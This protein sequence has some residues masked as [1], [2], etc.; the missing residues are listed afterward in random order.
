MSNLTFYQDL[1]R[2]EGPLQRLFGA[3]SDF[4]PVPEDWQVIVVDIEGSSQAVKNGLHQEVNLAATGS[5]IAVLNHIK[6]RHGDLVIPYWFGGDGATFLVPA[7]LR[8]ELM[9]TLENYRHHVKQQFFM[10]LRVGSVGVREVY[11]AGH[12]IRLVKAQLNGHLVVPIA[13]GNGLKHGEAL[14]KSCF[15]DETVVPD[16]LDEVDLTGMECR[17]NEIAPPFDQEQI[18]CVI[19]TCDDEATQPKVFESVMTKIT[20]IFGSLQERQPISVTRLKL[21]LTIGKIQREMYACLGRFN[22]TYLLKH[23]VTTIFGKYYFKFFKDGKR[24]LQQVSELSTTL[25]VDGNI[26]SVIS[27]TAE[28][29]AKLTEFLEALEGEGVLKFGVHTTYASVLSCY[30]VDRTANH[31]HFVDGTEGGFTAAARMFK[32]KLA[33]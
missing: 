30:V 19:V 27:G 20:S 18:L 5:I 4:Q 8:D 21:N 25:M 29:I 17:W 31:I 9:A 28:E 10:S 23:W 24:Y 32:A 2:R 6:T 26:N 7:S 16:H 15:I 3:P 33:A 13:L 22:M 12:T 11:A 1:P 14:I